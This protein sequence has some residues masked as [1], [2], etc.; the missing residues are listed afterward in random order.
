MKQYYNNISSWK[1]NQLTFQ[2][3]MDN[4]FNA[5]NCQPCDAT[6]SNPYQTCPIYNENGKKQCDRPQG[7]NTGVSGNVNVYLSNESTKEKGALVNYVTVTGGMIYNMIPGE[8]YY[9]ESA[10]D[11]NI[12]G[13]VKALGERRIVDAGA[14]RNVR[15][16]GGLEVDSDGDG[17]ADGKLKYGRA[18]RGVR[19]ATSSD[20]LSLEKLGITE[21][22][23]LRGSQTDPQ[24]S[25]YVPLAITNYEIDK[26]NYSSNYTAL[27]NAL[28]K[29]MDDVINGQNIFFHCK[30]GTDRTGTF[31]Y[32]LEGL[33]GVSEEDRL[34]DYELSYFYGVLNRHRFYSYQ[35]GSS[36][37][38][39]FVY[40]H[41]L[42][43]TN[44]DI[45][46]YYMSG[47]TDAT[48]DADAQRVIDFRNAMI[49]Y[50]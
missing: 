45:Y 24:L 6:A 33:L 21:E 38:H 41:D 12:Y 15:D 47:S 42:Y 30:I 37:T 44:E 14:V 3:N 25:N 35:P 43:P 49:N 26:E 11:T 5:Y 1:D 50:Y 39:R 20:I 46:N 7:F 48:R 19:L 10:E 28:T 13:T 40:M 18:F 16:L 27:R 2:I 22:I 4:N 31:A 8:T 9:W 17:T 23:D 32:F 34:Q 29:A 36:I